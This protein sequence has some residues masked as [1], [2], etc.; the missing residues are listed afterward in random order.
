[1]H[2][3]TKFSNDSKLQALITQI[4]IWTL[5][6]LERDFVVLQSFNLILNTIMMIIIQVIGF[7][8]YEIQS[9]R[10]NKTIA[11]SSKREKNCSDYSLTEGLST[12]MS[13]FTLHNA[14]LLDQATKCF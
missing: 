2:L 12:K 10:V 7:L 8:M 1:V 9:L 4:A 13:I 6:L 3:L 11:V 5:H 14:S